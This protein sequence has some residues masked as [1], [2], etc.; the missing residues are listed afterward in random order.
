MMSKTFREG[1]FNNLDDD[2]G[3]VKFKKTKSK[4]K[5][6]QVKDYLK[7]IEIDE[8]KEDEDIFENFEG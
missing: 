5:R 6:H 4:T 3:K 1:Y 2:W 8:I 7:Q